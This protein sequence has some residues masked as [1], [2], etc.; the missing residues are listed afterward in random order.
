MERRSYPTMY[1]SRGHL[2]ALP[3]CSV[4]RVC[5]VCECVGVGVG[6][7]ASDASCL[8][9][10]EQLSAAGRPLFARRLRLASLE[11]FTE[12]YQRE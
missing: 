5:R 2:S 10:C 8:C 6:A 1:N 7:S 3:L 9:G 12:W 4:C 11:I